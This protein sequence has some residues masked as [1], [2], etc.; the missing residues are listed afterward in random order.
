MY[1]D[2]VL[3]VNIALSKTASEVERGFEIRYQLLT[4]K[5]GNT[6][7]MLQTEGE[8]GYPNSRQDVFRVDIKQFET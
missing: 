5:I 7:V 6:D 3:P 8:E 2:A 1:R 4:G